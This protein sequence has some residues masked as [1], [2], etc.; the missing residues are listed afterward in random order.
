MLFSSLISEKCPPS[1]F[2]FCFILQVRLVFF[3]VF[4][5]VF[6]NE[7]TSS[8]SCG[9]PQILSMYILGVVSYLTFC[10][11]S[12]AVAHSQATER[13]HTSFF[14]TWVKSI[15]S[16]EGLWAAY[17]R[18]GSCWLWTGRSRLAAGKLSLRMKHTYWLVLSN[19][20]DLHGEECSRCGWEVNSQLHLRGNTQGALNP[21]LYDKLPYQ[22]VSDGAKIKWGNSEQ[23]LARN[24]P[25]CSPKP[26]GRKYELFLLAAKIGFKKKPR[27]MKGWYQ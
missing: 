6:N 5:F 14:L 12:L 2:K 15:W 8:H 26:A 23:H 13:L 17:T 11:L 9:F 7:L 3:F 16:G 27:Q 25:H 22:H 18:S 1:H 4:V 21:Y 19:L 20:M 10:T 24:Y